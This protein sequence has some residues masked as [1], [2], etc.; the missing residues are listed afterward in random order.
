MVQ[1]FKLH[2]SQNKTGFKLVH[3]ESNL[4][5]VDDYYSEQPVNAS[6]SYQLTEEILQ[7]Y[8]EC[9]AIATTNELVA[10]GV[11]DKLAEKN[12]RI[13]KKMAIISMGGTSIG[14][15]SRP[16]ITTVDFSPITLGTVATEL[17]M[18]VISKKRIRSSHLLLPTQLIE[19]EST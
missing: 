12:I 15:L 17:L 13:P 2:P 10:K 3:E 9:T 11:I 7:K 6:A 8:P 4:P 5:W 14:S 1:L 16:E 19:R 18:E